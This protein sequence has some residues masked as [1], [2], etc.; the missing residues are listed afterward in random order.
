MN[1]YLINPDAEHR[2]ILLIKLR[3]NAKKKKLPE[4]TSSCHLYIFNYHFQKNK[5]L[6]AFILGKGSAR[7]LKLTDLAH[8]RKASSLYDAYYKGIL[9]CF[10]SGRFSSLL[11]SISR[12]LINIGRVS[13]GSI[14]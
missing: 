8:F 4:N 14:I 10:F 3:W 11:A 6:L 12:A 1:F 7:N 5:E 13:L 9:P 2:G